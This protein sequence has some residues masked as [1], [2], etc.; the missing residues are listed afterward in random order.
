MNLGISTYFFNETVDNVLIIEYIKNG[1][2]D[3]AKI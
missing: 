2:D 3:Y 1:G